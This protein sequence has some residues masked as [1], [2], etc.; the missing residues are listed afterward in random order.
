MYLEIVG[1]PL[2]YVT[3]VTATETEPTDDTA[4]TKPADKGKAATAK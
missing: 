2:K 4:S 3:K 1:E